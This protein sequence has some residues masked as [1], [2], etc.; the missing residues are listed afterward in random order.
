MC[1]SYK[2]DT[3]NWPQWRGHLFTYHRGAQSPVSTASCLSPI[4]V[5]ASLPSPGSWERLRPQLEYS[6][7]G[8]RQGSLSWNWVSGWAVAKVGQGSPGMGSRF[9]T[10]WEQRS[11]VSQV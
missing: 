10:H 3:L 7:C 11:E 1:P 5:G 2:R 6:V 9:K 8:Q 4:P